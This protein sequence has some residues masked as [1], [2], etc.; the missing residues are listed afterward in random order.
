MLGGHRLSRGLHPR[1]TRLTECVHDEPFQGFGTANA[2]G[3]GE[4]PRA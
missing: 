2:L 3:L 4:A 1:L